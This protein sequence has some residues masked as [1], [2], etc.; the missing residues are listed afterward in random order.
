MG[1]MGLRGDE[2]AGTSASEAGLTTPPQDAG[3][4]AAAAGAGDAWSRLDSVAR[5]TESLRAEVA[6]LTEAV[7]ALTAVNQGLAGRLDELAPAW[8]AHLSRESAPAVAALP[9]D[10]VPDLTARIQT[11]VVALGAELETELRARTA[12]LAREVHESCRRTEQLATSLTTEMRLLTAKR[13][14]RDNQRSERLEHTTGQ[15]SH[16]AEE[17]AALR[18]QVEAPDEPQDWPD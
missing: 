3:N 14:A 13:E 10:F 5:E 9:P 17:L 12:S 2:T 11:A 18:R 16:L 8:D 4:G 15:L 6:R 7:E 1:A